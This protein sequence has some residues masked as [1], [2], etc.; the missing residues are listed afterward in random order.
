M[1]PRLVPLPWE[2]P[3]HGALGATQP[4]LIAASHFYSTV[5]MVACENASNPRPDGVSRHYPVG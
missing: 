2:F 5:T 3:L 1:S 4:P